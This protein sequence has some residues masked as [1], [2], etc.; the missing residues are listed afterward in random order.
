MVISSL[1]QYGVRSIVT[2]ATAW[3]LFIFCFCKSKLDSFWFQTE[4]LLE[5]YCVENVTAA[6]LQKAL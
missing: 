6:T 3:G 4:L 5:C 1:Y 2:F